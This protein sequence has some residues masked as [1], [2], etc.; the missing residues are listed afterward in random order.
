MTDPAPEA[1]K[2]APGEAA[3]AQRT[4]VTSPE[5]STRPKLTCAVATLSPHRE[6]E[7]WRVK[8]G[9]GNFYVQSGDTTTAGLSVG[10]VRLGCGVAGAHDRSRTRVGGRR[11]PP[12]PQTD[13]SDCACVC[14]LRRRGAAAI[15]IPAAR[16]DPA[17]RLRRGNTR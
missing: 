12:R 1:A 10:S 15:G 13:A 5:R 14:A 11:V 17:A 16:A 4:S 6:K 3:S 7:K 9:W 8:G 2:A